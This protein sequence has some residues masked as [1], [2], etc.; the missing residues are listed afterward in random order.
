MLL[1]LFNELTELLELFGAL[2]G[3]LAVLNIGLGDFSFNVK[4]LLLCLDTARLGESLAESGL[5]GILTFNLSFET[6]DCSTD[7]VAV[8]L[9]DFLLGGFSFTTNPLLVGIS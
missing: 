1:V 4:I 9:L 8:A 3:L 6:F 2:T 5:V 7:L